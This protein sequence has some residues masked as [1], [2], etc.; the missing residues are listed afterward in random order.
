MWLYQNA[1]EVT[2]RDIFL[3]LSAHNVLIFNKCLA[4]K[5]KNMSLQFHKLDSDIPTP[6]AFCKNE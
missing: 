2:G 5:Y 4:D 1:K 3:Y 6:I